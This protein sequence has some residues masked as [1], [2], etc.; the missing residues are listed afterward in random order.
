MESAG[1]KCV[2]AIVRLGEEIK[3]EEAG[4]PGS[5][6]DRRQERRHRTGTQHWLGRNTM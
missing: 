6:L 1:Q 3:G 2:E 4:E 5:N